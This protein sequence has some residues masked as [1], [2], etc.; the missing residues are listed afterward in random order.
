MPL[1]LKT[2]LSY[3][4]YGDFQ[5]VHDEVGDLAGDLQLIRKHDN[6]RFIF[7]ITKDPTIQTL[8]MLNGEI[9]LIPF[10]LTPELANHLAEQ[11]PF[12]LLKTP[13]NRYAY[14][15]INLQDEI[16]SHIDIR[17]AIAYSIDRQ[18]IID[19]LLHGRAA[20]ATSL[21]P[22]THWSSE[23]NLQQY[24]PNRQKAKA[25]LAKHGYDADNPLKLSFKSSK[26]VF[27]LR[28]AALLKQQL[29]AA[30]IH[31]NIQSYDWGTFYAD[32]K[33]GRFQLYSLAWVGIKQPDI[34]RYVF[35]SD[36]IPPN[37]A[38]RGRFIN[39]TVD[40]WIDE[41]DQAIEQPRK[42]HAYQQVQRIV[43]QQLPYIPLWYEDRYALIHQRLQHYQLSDDGSLLNLAQVTRSN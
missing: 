18:A 10:G 38:N 21:M 7:R 17:Q 34:Y 12:R 40:E 4:G 39:K 2:L 41:A 25:L 27:R 43:H 14:L 19:H 11:Q 9:D 37:G 23:P 26:N 33:E 15:G 3:S 28:I 20:L 22:P 24:I 35:H 29:Q 16:L 8:Q 30:N 32:V 13:G 42:T 31:L 6:Q 5:L 1:S 36:M